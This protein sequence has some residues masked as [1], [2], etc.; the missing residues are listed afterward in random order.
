MYFGASLEDAS[1]IGFDDAFQYEDFKLPWDKRKN[2]SVVPGFER[3]TGLKAY[4]AWMKK[5]DR[6]P[7]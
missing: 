2:I 5:A 7:Y 1:K 4:Q 3:E 6:H